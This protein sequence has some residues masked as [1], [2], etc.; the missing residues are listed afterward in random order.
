VASDVGGHHEL[1]TE[2]ETG[3]L[4]RAGDA[5]ALAGCV[6][7][8]AAD[9]QG[10]ARVRQQGRCFVEQQRNWAA[11]VARYAPVYESLMRP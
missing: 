11:S 8:V 5:Q 6:A 2:G 9:A 10:L 3:F 4:F 7:R 1:I